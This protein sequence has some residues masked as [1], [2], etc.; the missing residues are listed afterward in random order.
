MILKTP[1]PLWHDYRSL[2]GTAVTTSQDRKTKTLNPKPQTPNLKPK[3]LKPQTL[4]PK[5]QTLDPKPYTL[6]LIILK[7]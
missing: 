4:N 1:I 7:P 5:P 2:K 6:N 3:T